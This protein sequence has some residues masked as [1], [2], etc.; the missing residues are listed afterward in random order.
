MQAYKTRGSDGCA[1]TV[2]VV[3]CGSVGVGGTGGGS[4]C[5]DCS[6]TLDRSGRECGARRGAM[7]A[8]H[9]SD[10]GPAAA[11]RLAL[12]TAVWLKPANSTAV[13][14]G[15]PWSWPTRFVRAAR[16][17]GDN[18]RDIAR[19]AAWQPEPLRESR[20]HADFSI[21]GEAGGNDCNSALSGSTGRRKPSTRFVKEA[22][23]LPDT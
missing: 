23:P 21:A 16:C 2:S 11:A 12:A 13:K 5:S 3:V 17:A 6:R 22:T 7:C 20:C 19:F 10:R 1:R 8:E 9:C 4:S 18:D 14:R 15:A